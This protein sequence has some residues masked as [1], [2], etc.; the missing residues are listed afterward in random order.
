MAAAAI[1]DFQTVGILEVGRAVWR[2]LSAQIRLYQRRR[3]GEGQEGQNAST[4]AKVRGDRS[5]RCR[6]MAIYLFFNMAAVC[7]LWFIVP[8]FG[9]PTK[10]IWC[11]LRLC[12][13]WLKSVQ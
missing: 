12:K 11:S 10:S 2:P 9:P 6:N 4:R 5:N 13:T 3:D 1:L 8:M 7:H